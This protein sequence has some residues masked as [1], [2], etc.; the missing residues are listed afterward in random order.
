MNLIG[1]KKKTFRKFIYV[2]KT[3]E[4]YTIYKQ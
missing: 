4:K 2:P 1:M 3:S